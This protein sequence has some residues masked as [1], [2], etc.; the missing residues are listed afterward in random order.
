MDGATKLKIFVT[1][2]VRKSS[3]A[4]IRDFISKSHARGGEVPGPENSVWGGHAFARA[5]GRR[6]RLKMRQCLTGRQGANKTN[7]P[8][9]PERTL[10]IA[11]CGLR[12]AGRPLGTL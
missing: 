8:R 7:E 4:V 5:G 10:R 9:N 2:F 1:A 6:C 12:I 11:D 3:V